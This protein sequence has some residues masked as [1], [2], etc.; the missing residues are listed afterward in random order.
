LDECVIIIK[1]ILI[2]FVSQA[3]FSKLNS[4]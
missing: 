3:M 1:D 4:I 2:S